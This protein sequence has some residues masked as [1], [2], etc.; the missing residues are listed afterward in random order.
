MTHHVL[1][2]GE[3]G[4]H[5]EGPRLAGLHKTRRFS[6]RAVKS[7]LQILQNIIVHFQQDLSLLLLYLDL[8][9]HVDVALRVL[10]HHVLHIVRLSL[11]YKWR[12][13]FS[14]TETR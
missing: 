6:H 1:Q 9:H 2:P 4:H 5:R 12:P 3:P 8:L 10:L 13:V 7:P 11:R 14:S